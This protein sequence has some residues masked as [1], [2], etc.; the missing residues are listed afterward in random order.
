MPTPDTASQWA[1]LWAIELLNFEADATIFFRQAYKH[2]ATW[3]GSALMA[4]LSR[5]G[6]AIVV[7]GKGQPKP[8][9]K[10]KTGQWTQFVDIPL[11]GA[12]W[13]DIQE[14]FPDLDSCHDALA[15]L[16]VDGYRVSFAYNPQS[17][18]IT[19]SVTCKAAGNPNEGKTFTSFAASWA[20][21][22]EIALYKHYV[23]AEGSWGS[24]EDGADTPAFG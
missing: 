13:A 2:M 15:E 12:S 18:A 5:Y 4:L 8:A 21:A 9:V 11:A 7:R 19:C 23:I 10:P 24:R 20:S 3:R 22:L 14:A 16:I 1:E 17:N 6:D